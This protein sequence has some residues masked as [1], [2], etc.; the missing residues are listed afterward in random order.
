MPNTGPVKIGAATPNDLSELL[1]LYR[2]LNPDDPVLPLDDTLQLHW[3]AILNNPTLHYVVARIDGGIVSTCN[4]TIIPNLT[5]SARPYGLIENVVTDPNY[6]K[7]GIGTQVLRHALAI[8]WEQDC[9]KVMLLP[10]SKNEA[11]LRFYEQA[12]FIRGEKTGLVARPRG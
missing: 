3:Q 6:R 2:F 4:L 9:Y 12:G 10:G 1:A 11:T 5:R 7:Q 8:A